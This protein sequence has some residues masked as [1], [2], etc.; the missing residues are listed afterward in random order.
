MDEK[1]KNY[2]CE[3]CGGELKD[4]GKGRFL[5]PYC[6]TEFF[7]EVS[8]PEELVF[9]LYTAGFARK[10]NR[11]EEALEMYDTIIREYP[12]CFDAYWGATL[13]DYG[14]QYE[15]DYDG[16]MVPTVHR[17]SETPISTNYYFINAVKRCKLKHERKRIEKSA[18]E[19]EKIRAQIKKTVGTQKPY[20][21]FLCYKETPIG[22]QGFY[23]PEFKWAHNLYMD[24]TDLGYKVFFAKECL[25]TAAGDYEA[26]IFPALRS[27][28]LML[29]L[30]SSVEHVESVWVKNEWSRFIR[31]AAENPD[32]GKRFKV[33]YSG[34][35]PE[36]LP[37]ALCKEQALDHDDNDWFGDLKR[38]IEDTF[39]DKQKLQEERKKKEVEEQTSLF[40]RMLAEERKRWESEEAARRKEEV[41]ER[42]K[43]EA[44]RDK[45]DEEERK[46]REEEDRRRREE[47]DR[48]RREDEERRKR[49]EDGGRYQ[50]STVSYANTYSSGAY[51]E[52]SSYA[53]LQL[54]DGVYKGAT[55]NGIPHGKG[56]MFYSD[57]DV[58]DGQFA[59]GL[60]NG[61]GKF[62]FS[63]GAEYLGDVVD[64]DQHGQGKMWFKN[65][66]V[67]EGSWNY[68]KMHGKGEYYWEKNDDVYTGDFVNGHRTGYGK[69]ETYSDDKEGYFERNKFM[70]KTYGSSANRKYVSVHTSEGFYT[71][72]AINGVPYG[73]GKIKFTNGDTY[74]GPFIAGQPNGNGKFVFNNGT[75]YTGG[76]VDGNQ[77]G[78]GV[79]TY[80]GGG[81]YEGIWKDDKLH[82]KGTYRY[83][84]G[85][86]YTGDWFYGART[87]YGKY[88]YANG[89]VE[90]GYFKDGKLIR[91]K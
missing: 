36:T 37:R 48:R 17:F 50:N 90:E 26:H 31:F 74:E 46:R 19:I 58:Y 72:Y 79:M 64:G 70:G 23:T 1:L 32:A 53:E 47:D 27:A 85:D 38:V 86:V 30:T 55:L 51:S 42:E 41:A 5:C 29:I 57:G 35:K 16:K 84:N 73:E 28:K 59:G 77:H 45:R 4:M 43:R 13:S 54:H 91:R 49:D 39:L 20:D 40:A 78:Y 21:I 60:P 66:D 71:G 15:K 67:Y 82:G 83:K 2:V 80:A 8:L 62:I 88:T 75:V 3:K 63:S 44:E 14:I 76:V 22:G 12:D 10:N 18:A 11:F 24:L 89:R 34:F 25:T 87:G 81:S 33:I 65:G 7:K 9:N 6:K 68:D 61:K 69:L 52:P 56:K